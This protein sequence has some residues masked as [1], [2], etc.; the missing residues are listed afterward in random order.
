MAVKPA[1]KTTAIINHLVATIRI[2]IHVYF[3]LP[4]RKVLKDFPEAYSA[5]QISM[6]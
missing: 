4:V 3:A 5:M 6:P 2:K 1:A